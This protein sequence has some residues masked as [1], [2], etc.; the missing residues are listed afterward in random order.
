MSGQWPTLLDV[1]LR[2]D[3]QG[4]IH[5]LAEMLSQS[6]DYFNDAV[7]MEANEMA[8]HQFAFRTSIPAGSWRQI[9]QGVP[10]SK[11]TS[12]RATVGVASLEDYSQVDRLLAEQ[13]GD[14]EGFRYSEDVAFLEGM[15]Q[16]MVQTQFYGNTA[17][18]PAEFMGLSPFYNTVSTATAQNAANVL[19]AGGVN[20]A[21][22]SIWLICHGAGKMYN[23]YPRGSKA[24][25]NMEDKGDIVPGYDSFG[26][27][28]EAFTSWFRQQAGFVPHDWRYGG[29]IANID[30]TA[31]G[32]AGPNAYDIFAGIR[33]MFM[34][35]PNMTA[36]SSGI[37]STDAP[38]DPGTGIRPVLYCN[39]TVRF[40]MD[41]Q[42]IR[43]RNVLLTSTDYAGKPVMKFNDVPIR[44]VDQLLNTEARVV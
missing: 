7:W 5:H 12:A 16:T 17:A 40:R 19:D 39:R 37:T 33:Q 44:V 22:A 25:L 2:L 38:N 9:N 21:N 30:V 6:N 3:P 36:E 31:A 15:A 28:F 42:A 11:S 32:L 1:S 34:L 26:N 35:P 8:G 27:R 18:T 14:I 23:V 29:R 24:G 20:S 4:K 10:Y 43:D 41:I 13:S